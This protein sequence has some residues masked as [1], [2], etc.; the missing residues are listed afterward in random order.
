MWFSQKIPSIFHKFSFNSKKKWE[1]IIFERVEM[2]K[3]WNTIEVEGKKSVKNRKIHVWKAKQETIDG[4]FV[5]TTTFTRDNWS[6]EKRFFLTHCNRLSW[7]RSL[8]WK[9]E[10]RR[11]NSHLLAF[12]FGQM[13]VYKRFHV[14]DWKCAN[15][16]PTITISL[17]CVVKLTR[18]SSS[19]FTEIRSHVGVSW[20][21]STP[22]RHKLAYKFE[23][24]SSSAV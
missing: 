17:Y 1:K 12:Y 19:L 24:L 6:M 20:L 11:K 10:K 21:R 7:W 5:C 4:L 22:T 13:N 2:E 3:F 15:S 14:W 23:S 18:S 8:S 16:Q 9:M